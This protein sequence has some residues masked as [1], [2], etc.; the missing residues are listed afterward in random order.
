MAQELDLEHQVCK[1]HVKRNTE[2]FIDNLES[3]VESDE[4]GSLAAIRVTP[5]Q[6]LQDLGRLGEL[7]LS[8]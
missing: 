6:A 8:R 3:K 2:T 5:E 4:D 7:I 1:G